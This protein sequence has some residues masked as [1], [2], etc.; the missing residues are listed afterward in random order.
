[1][2]PWMWILSQGHVNLGFDYVSFGSGDPYVL[3]TLGQGNVNMGL[4]HLKLD[5]FY[6]KLWVRVIW[7][8]GMDQANLL[9]EL[10]QGWMNL[11]LSSFE[12]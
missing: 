4:G 6:P 12:P 11:G 9:F 7:T 2:D 1:M 10:G 5:W 3:S 8:L